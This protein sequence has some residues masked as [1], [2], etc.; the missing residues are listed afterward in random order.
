MTPERIAELRAFASKF[1]TNA[2]TASVVAECLD[3]IERLQGENKLLAAGHI[4]RDVVDKA[5]HKSAQTI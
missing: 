2:R 4:A 5:Q 1:S 3:E